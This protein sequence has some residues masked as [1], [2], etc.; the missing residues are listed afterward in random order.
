MPRAK[1][2]VS[3]RAKLSGIAWFFETAVENGEK[4]ETSQRSERTILNAVTRN[5][6]NT[7]PS[8]ST[9][10]GQESDVPPVPSVPSAAVLP[11]L[12]ASDL[13]THLPVQCPN[14]RFVSLDKPYQP[15]PS[16]IPTQQTAK[17]T[18][19]F[20]KSWYDAFNWLHFDSGLKKVV[21]F[22][23]VKASVMGLSDLARCKEPVFISQGF[24]NWKKAIDKFKAHQKSHTQI[25]AVNQLAAAK[26]PTICAQLVA[27]AEEQK[28]ARIAILKLFTS[29][30]YVQRQGSAFRG[31]D[32]H[33][34]GNYLQLFKL[35]AEDVPDLNAYLNLTTNFTSPAAQNEMMQMFSHCILR[36][37]IREVQ[38]NGFFAL[39]TDGTQDVKGLEQ[40][41]ICIRHVDSDLYIHEDFIGLYEISST[42]GDVLAHMTFDV[43]SRF[44]LCISNLCAQTYDGAANMSGCYSG[45]QARVRERQLLALYFH[46]GSHASNLVMQNAVTLCQLIRDAIQWVNEFGVLM[47]RSGKPKA[48]FKGICDS[49]DEEDDHH[50]IP[51]KE[52]KPLCAT[53][54]L[55]RLEAIQSVVSQYPVVLQSLEEMAGT[56][57]DTATKANG[58]FE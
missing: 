6:S 7:A 5:S 57:S 23:C 4:S 33:S 53:R 12:S 49:V 24:N 42:T 19:S 22:Y 46:C 45:C 8:S 44:G 34:V 39:S 28:R 18:L 32:H 48:L 47:K 25:L 37:I 35:R 50:P 11:P 29:I 27:Q 14:S 54:W 40:E 41:S 52:V 55:C 13:P 30:R 10:T 2:T 3:K 21:C 1:A 15:D 17:R 36:D 9:S 26:Q 58:F 43:L 51:M 38:M 56:R 31:H 16:V 20:Q